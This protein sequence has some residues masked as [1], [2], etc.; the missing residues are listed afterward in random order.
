MRDYDRL[1]SGRLSRATFRRALDLCRFGLNV[2]QYTLIESAF[3]SP[4]QEGYVDYVK[5]CDEIESAITV[6]G[7]YTERFIM[8]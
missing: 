6:K 8:F 1:R 3:A 5:F 2:N 4:K 7:N